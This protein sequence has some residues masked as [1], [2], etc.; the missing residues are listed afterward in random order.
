MLITRL[1]N[2]KNITCNGQVLRIR[3]E[4]KNINNIHRQWASAQN[5]SYA[6]EIQGLFG[7]L[8]RKSVTGQLHKRMRD[9]VNCTRSTSTRL[10]AQK[11]AL[12]DNEAHCTIEAII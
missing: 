11:N 6:V 2:K 7:C 4:R 1:G 10:T 12:T 8:D 9:H 5:V 3:I